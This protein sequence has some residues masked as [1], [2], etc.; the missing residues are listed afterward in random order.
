[1]GLYIVVKGKAMTAKIK[2]TMIVQSLIR[3]IVRIPFKMIRRSFFKN[4]PGKTSR[5][6]VLSTTLINLKFMP[7]KISKHLRNQILQKTK[8]FVLINS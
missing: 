7:Q 2:M 3:R 4:A 8:I 5:V 6:A 1:M